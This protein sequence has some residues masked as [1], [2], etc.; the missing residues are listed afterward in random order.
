MDYSRGLKCEHSYF[1]FSF[2]NFLVPNLMKFVV[3]T[4]VMLYYMFH[5]SFCIDLLVTRNKVFLPFFTS[6]MTLSALFMIL[7][8]ILLQSSLILLIESMF[9]WLVIFIQYYHIHL[10]PSLQEFFCHNFGVIRFFGVTTVYYL[11]TRTYMY[12][13]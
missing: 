12:Y 6:I 10:T 1:D 7:F 13:Q 3:F 2:K 11:H 4:T 5:F 9:N 8:A